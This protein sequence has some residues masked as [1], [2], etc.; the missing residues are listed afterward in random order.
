MVGLNTKTPQVFWNGV[1]VDG[2]LG[3]AVNSDAA[4]RKVVLRVKEDPVIAEMQAAG[5]FVRRMAA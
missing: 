3:I 2:V 5:V 4:A 1:K